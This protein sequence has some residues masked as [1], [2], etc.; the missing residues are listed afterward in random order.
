M[1]ASSFNVDYRCLTRLITGIVVD[2][3]GTLFD[4]SRTDIRETL[5]GLLNQMYVYYNLQFHMHCRYLLVPS[6]DYNE[7]FG[8]R[9]SVKLESFQ[10]LKETL[11]K[12]VQSRALATTFSAMLS[13]YKEA[14]VDF[15]TM[16]E[17]PN[18]LVP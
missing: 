10:S 2:A 12:M 5:V 15:R 4:L 6:T 17:C 14:V 11:L 16:S 13:I 1:L 18:G 3:L 9:C 7:T 8:Q